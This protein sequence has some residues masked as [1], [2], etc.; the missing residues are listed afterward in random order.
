M[1][2]RS[3][4]EAPESIANKFKTVVDDLLR[5]NGKGLVLIHRAQGAH[6]L[7]AFL[8][9]FCE[10]RACR[11]KVGYLFKCLPRERAADCANRNREVLET[12]NNPNNED[13][14]TMKIIIADAK[15]FSEGV[16]FF[17]V[18][19]FAMVNP[20]ESWGA[21]KQQIGRVLRSCDMPGRHIKLR[22]YVSVMPSSV[23]IHRIFRLQQVGFGSRRQQRRQTSSLLN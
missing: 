21:Y 13:G 10:S 14:S 8:R 11:G 6:G 12:F 23:V 4:M 18:M 1:I 5:E 20:P 7:E 3:M 16:S 17:K 15:D 2:A 19:N 22:M 9:E